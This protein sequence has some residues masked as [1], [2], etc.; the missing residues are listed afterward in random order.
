MVQPSMLLA[1]AIEGTTEVQHSQT[2]ELLSRLRL[3]QYISGALFLLMIPAVLSARR[4]RKQ[5]QALFERAKRLSQ[6]NQEMEGELLKTEQMMQAK[7]KEKSNLAEEV[8][9]SPEISDKIRHGIFDH[10]V[11]EQ[12]FLN[13][14]CNAAMLSNAIGTNRTYLNQYVKSQFGTTVSEYINDLR[15][16]YVL[17]LLKVDPAMRKFTI[18]RMAGDSGFNSKRTFERAFRARTGITP[19]FYIRQLEAEAQN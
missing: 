1:G 13:P 11:R 9:L 8:E 12:M 4:K 5:N 10:L 2:G 19:A 14:Q 3:F 18:E 16:F 17:E 6:R 7:T 15:L